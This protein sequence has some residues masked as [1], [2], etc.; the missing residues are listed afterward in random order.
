MLEGELGS[1]EP[2]PISMNILSI[3]YDNQEAA[4]RSDLFA[5]MPN[6]EAYKK[7]ILT[8]VYSR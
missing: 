6:K 8:G 7:E 3:P 2:A 1:S 4:D 5:D